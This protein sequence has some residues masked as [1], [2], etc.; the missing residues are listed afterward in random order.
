MKNSITFGNKKTKNPLITLS[1]S[2]KPTEETKKPQ[3]KS[4]YC[5]QSAL[6]LQSWQTT[7]RMTVVP[8]CIAGYATWLQVTGH[9]V[10]FRLC[11]LSIPIWSLLSNKT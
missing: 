1:A 10:C 6:S 5:S 2:G 9:Q 8:R 11:E 7:Y 3:V 4:R